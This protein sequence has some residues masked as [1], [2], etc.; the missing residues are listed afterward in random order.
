[1]RGWRS[2]AIRMWSGRK[3]GCGST[4]SRVRASLAYEVGMH[5]TRRARLVAYAVAVLAP[6]ATLLV[7]MVSHPGGGRQGSVITFA[8]PS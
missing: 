4:I 3:Q 1:M 5:E 2:A 7:P 8:R 6:A